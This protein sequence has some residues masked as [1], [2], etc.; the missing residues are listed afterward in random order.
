[1]V[2]KVFRNRLQVRWRLLAASTM[3]PNEGGLVES[4]P[5]LEG[6]E[7]FTAFPQPDRKDRAVTQQAFHRITSH[8]MLLFPPFQLQCLAAGQ[9]Q[10]AIRTLE[11][12]GGGAQQ[13]LPTQLG[14]PPRMPEPPGAPG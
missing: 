4:Q 1:M 14:A 7:R 6:R 13:T 12:T 3:V 10:D 9:L 5:D 2:D 11:L 8:T